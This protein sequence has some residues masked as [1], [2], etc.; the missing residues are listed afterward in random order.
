MDIS[1][2]LLK[3]KD[4]AKVAP[5]LIEP[6]DKA[7]QATA[8]ADLAKRAKDL[9][10]PGERARRGQVVFSRGRSPSRDHGREW[11]RSERALSRLLPHRSQSPVADQPLALLVPETERE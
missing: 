9:L 3:E 1:D 11:S 2:K 6:L 4:S 5:K 8:N 7:A 10:R